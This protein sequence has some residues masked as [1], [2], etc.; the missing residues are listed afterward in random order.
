MYVY[1]LGASVHTALEGGSDKSPLSQLL[2]TMMARE[3]AER[4]S[5]QSVVSACT[6]YTPQEAITEVDALVTLVFGTAHDV[7]Q[8]VLIFACGNRSFYPGNVWRGGSCQ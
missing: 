1:G 6:Q 3:P 2:A 4:P 5:L 7:C 8:C